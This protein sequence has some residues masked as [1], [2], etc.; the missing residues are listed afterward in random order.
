MKFPNII[1]IADLVV[2]TVGLAFHNEQAELGVLFSNNQHQL[3]D[4]IKNNDPIHFARMNHITPEQKNFTT[5]HFY[6][7]LFV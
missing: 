3:V 4:P 5:T 1:F 2:G 6:V 7:I